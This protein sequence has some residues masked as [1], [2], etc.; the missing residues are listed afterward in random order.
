MNHTVYTLYSPEYDKIYI[1]RTSDLNSRMISH[2]EKGTK[3]WTIRYRPWKV[4]F[5]EEFDTKQQA[6]HREKELKSSR[7][8][9]CVWERVNNKFKK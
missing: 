5:T 1:G 7:G 3:G 9:A 2:N 4:V 6:I 8:R